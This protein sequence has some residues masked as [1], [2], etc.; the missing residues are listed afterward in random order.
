MIESL[1]LSAFLIGFFL[2][3]AHLSLSQCPEKL[4]PHANHVLLPAVSSPPSLSATPPDS[5]QPPPFWA[6][7]L[8]SSSLWSL[9]GHRGPA[10][11]PPSGLFE[12]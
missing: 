4:S 5:R 3:G 12:D 2:R 7:A 6:D 8:G 9:L 11:A 1:I 10:S